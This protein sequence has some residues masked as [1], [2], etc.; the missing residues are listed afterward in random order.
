MTD[1]LKFSPIWQ[2]ATNNLP[3]L[4]KYKLHNNNIHR[5]YWYHHSLPNNDS[6]PGNDVH[7]PDFIQYIKPYYCPRK[8]TY[9]GSTVKFTKIYKYIEMFDEVFDIDRA[10]AKAIE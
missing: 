4:L 1:R 8:T 7:C 10:F 9:L 3:N 6:C 2:V 5:S